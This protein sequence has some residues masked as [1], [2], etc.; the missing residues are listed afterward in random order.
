MKSDV[1]QDQEIGLLIKSKACEENTIRYCNIARYN[2][3][4]YW[5]ISNVRLCDREHCNV[6]CDENNAAALHFVTNGDN[7][8]EK[9][10][11]S[12]DHCV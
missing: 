7:G 6:A 11:G 1:M 9:T 12:S 10:G 8:T 4:K 2:V 5:D 3:I